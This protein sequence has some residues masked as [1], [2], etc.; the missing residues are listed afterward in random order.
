[1]TIR[2]KIFYVV[3]PILVAPLVL[4]LLV[5]VLSTR[6]GISNIASKHLTFKSRVLL[7]YMENQ[8]NLLDNNNFSDNPA[9]ITASKLSIE[10]YARGLV[11]Q[12]EEIIFALDENKGI[13]IS[14]EIVEMNSGALDNIM[15]N[16]DAPKSGWI[17]F[18]LN[19]I[20]YISDVQH[21]EP[22]QWTVVNSIQKKSFYGSIVLMIE[23]I[24]IIFLISLFISIILLIV[25]SGYLTK[26]LH[27]IAEVIRSI[28]ESNNLSIKVDVFFDDEIGE[29]SHYF[30]IMTQE[31]ESANKQMKEY[32]LKAVISKRN[33]MKIR[34]IFQ[35][36][37]PQNI[38][39][40]IYQDP[41]SILKGDSQVLGILFSD[42]REFTTFSEKLPPYEV[43]ESL[44]KYFEYMVNI[45]MDNHGIVDKYI[46]DAIMAFFGAPVHHKND[47]LEATETGL[48]MLEKVKEF[49]KWQFKYGKQPFKIGVG[50]NYGFVT[51]GNIGTEKKMDY[52]VIGDMV[53]MA[54]RLEG[55]TK[56]YHEPILI[57]D[58]VHRKVKESL[59]CRLVD[60]VVVKGKTEEKKIYSVRKE[61]S[62]KEKELWDA[63]N[64]GLLFYYKKEFR[65]AAHF[66]K[67]ALL[68]D[69]QDF[70]SKNFLLRCKENMS[71]KLDNNWTGAVISTTK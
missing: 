33:E 48:Q 8:W 32:A 68:I 9:Y 7:Q 52:T 31:L 24:L 3:L 17:E 13:A 56:V 11:E 10:D 44:N 61:L 36:Y 27:S 15:G 40:Q 21:F 19:G 23:R 14:S 62:V 28:I 69:H 43:V 51:I 49:N 2:S 12:G 6:N 29:I 71:I 30:N 54:S 38:I 57:S 41:H 26:P 47:A 59:P 66:F 1:M 64:E 4:T 22:F 55:L 63:Y 18:S 39:N 60:R 45:I 67:N 42:I 37:V 20:P 25:L 65:K 50:I 53:N 58:S 34:N 46:G 16:T 70:C 35:K 5:G